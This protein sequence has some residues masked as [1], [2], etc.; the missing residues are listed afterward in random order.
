MVMLAPTDALD[1][2]CAADVETANATATIEHSEYGA[3]A[4]VD[5]HGDER[6]ILVT[7][8]SGTTDLTGHTDGLS[9]GG[10]YDADE[11]QPSETL[12]Q[13]RRVELFDR[14]SNVGGVDFAEVALAHPQSLPML[15]QQDL[16]TA[17]PSST[18]MKWPSPDVNLNCVYTAAY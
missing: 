3:R 16:I 14:G 4:V 5:R 12:L 8:A 13:P 7:R 1:D 18:A 6:R 11:P 9:F 15:Q 17:P 2:H 10:F